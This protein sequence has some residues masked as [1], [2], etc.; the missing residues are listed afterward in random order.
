MD[1]GRTVFTPLDLRLLWQ[2]SER[3]AK[4][5]AVRMVERKIIIRLSKGYYALNQKYNPYELANRIITPSYV[6]FQSALAFAGV[7]FQNRKEIGSV[8]GLNYRKKIGDT[9]YIYYTMKKLLLFSMEG[10]FT[11]DGVTIASPERAILDSFYF[12]F[13][14]DIDNEEKLNKEYLLKLSVL[15]PKTVQEKAKKFYERTV[16]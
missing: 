8:A 7:S 6:S 4:V 3:N 12:N 13:L 1:S 11:R 15:Y 16:Q 2:E 9:A 10:I 5:N 14:P